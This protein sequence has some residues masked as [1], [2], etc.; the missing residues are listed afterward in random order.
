M[1][2]IEPLPV[3]VEELPGERNV[4]LVACG[5]GDET[6]RVDLELYPVKDEATGE[7]WFC[8]EC[9]CKDWRTRCQPAIRKLGLIAVCKHIVR[10]RE[11]VINRALRDAVKGKRK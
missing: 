6:Y 9:E 7:L 8:G 4:F 3:L 11:Y 1:T 5:N 2:I 10:A